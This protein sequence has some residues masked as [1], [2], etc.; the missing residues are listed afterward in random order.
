MATGLN[1]I[2]EFDLPGPDIG[3]PVH[4]TRP[5]SVGFIRREGGNHGVEQCISLAIAKMLIIYE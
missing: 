1:E 3:Q 2:K 4:Y 5:V